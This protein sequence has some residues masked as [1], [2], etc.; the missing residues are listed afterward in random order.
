MAKKATKKRV[1]VLGT[2]ELISSKQKYEVMFILSP[3]LT[4]D[5]RKKLLKELEDQITSKEGEIY[6]IEDWGKRNIAY[7]IK[8]QTEGYYMVYHFILVDR[9]E[10]RELDEFMRLEQSIL[11]HLIVKRDEDFVI[12]DFQNEEEERVERP[13]AN[14][15]KDA[16]APRSDKSSAA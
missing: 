14:L 4:E 7:K 5:R 6:H 9:K 16:K 12:R 3:M 13:G 11:R 8:K 10:V 15:K 2:D 1:S